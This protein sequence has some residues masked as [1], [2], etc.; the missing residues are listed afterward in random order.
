MRWLGDGGMSM[1]FYA[2]YDGV[3]SPVCVVFCYTYYFA[4]K[5]VCM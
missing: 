1:G 4:N 2:I 3:V 5:M